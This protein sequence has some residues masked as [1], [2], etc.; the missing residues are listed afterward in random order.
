MR[1]VSPNV[2]KAGGEGVPDRFWARSPGHHSGPV[3]PGLGGTL[4]GL[5]GSLTGFWGLSSGTCSRGLLMGFFGIPDG[6][7]GVPE[8]L[9]GSRSWPPCTEPVPSGLGGSLIGFLGG[10]WVYYIGLL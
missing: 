3:P 9:L 4:M 6:I 1:G 10:Y 2:P 5:L 8:V 7:L